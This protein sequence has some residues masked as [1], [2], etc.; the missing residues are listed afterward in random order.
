MLLVKGLV[1]DSAPETAGREH[2]ANHGAKLN[3]TVIEVRRDRAG[4]LD[5]VG[6][7]TNVKYVQ[8]SEQPGMGG[9]A[10]TRISWS[11]DHW[12]DD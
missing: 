4:E 9:R 12:S 6:L 1:E 5:L 2:A 10:Q 7:E 11:D 3:V 8:Y